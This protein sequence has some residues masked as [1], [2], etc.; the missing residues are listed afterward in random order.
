M[1][2][3]FVCHLQYSPGETDMIV[4]KHT[5]EVEYNDKLSHRETITSTLIDIGQQNKNIN[6]NNNSKNNTSDG[7]LAGF[8]SM[9]RTVSLPV[10]IAI[11]AWMEGRI[12]RDCVGVCRPVK[13][14]IYNLIL[15]EMM[16]LGV[17][18]EEQA[19]KIQ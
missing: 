11:R 6:S 3:L 18:F 17:K 8:S 1:C 14:E 13:K 10:A 12:S 15:S 4:M 2:Y 7:T 16:N 19:Q 5:F 9:A